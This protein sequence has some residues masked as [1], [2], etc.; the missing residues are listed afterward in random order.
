MRRWY[1]A[2][3]GPLGLIVAG[4]AIAGWTSRIGWLLVLAGAVLSVVALTAR[5]RRRSHEARDETPAPL[6]EH[7]PD[8][9]VVELK[10]TGGSERSID[11]SARVANYGTQQCRAAFRAT[12]NGETVECVPQFHDLVPNTEPKRVAIYVP[13]QRLGSLVDAFANEPTLYGRTLRFEAVADSSRAE[14]E[15][16]EKLYDPESN[17]KRYEI[18]Q[19]LW[20][21]G[22]G[23]LAER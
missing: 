22:R 7:R 13:R 21:I 17:R 23:D 20:R 5:A 19:R 1:A 15:W 6:P 8:L 4:L 18:Q 3:G 9:R 11:F 16:T 12:V 10:N 2:I 14:A